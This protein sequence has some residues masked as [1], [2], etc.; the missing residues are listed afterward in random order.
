MASNLK[1]DDAL[2]QQ[3]QDLSGLKT[4]REVVNQALKEFVER[5]NQRELI[6]LRGQFDFDPAYD[7]KA[8]R[9]RR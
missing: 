1:L 7:Y 5:Y 2:V 8:E 6:K 9:K 4:K 3:A